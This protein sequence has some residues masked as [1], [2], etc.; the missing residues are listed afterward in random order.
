VFGCAGPVLSGSGPKMKKSFLLG[1]E[2]L[3]E[4]RK[5][6]KKETKITSSSLDKAL[7]PLQYGIDLR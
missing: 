6:I 1:V 5:E 7:W 4:R 2:V 3:K